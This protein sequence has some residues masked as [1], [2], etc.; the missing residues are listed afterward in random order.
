MPT[1]AN[2]EAVGLFKAKL[3]TCV[4]VAAQA[5][6]TLGK[7]GGTGEVRVVRVRRGEG[8]QGLW[9]RACGGGSTAEMEAPLLLLPDG[10]SLLPGNGILQVCAHLAQSSHLLSYDL[11]II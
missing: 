3:M 4:G 5:D 8:A 1:D 6:R 11:S 7:S 2:E 10:F 9:Q